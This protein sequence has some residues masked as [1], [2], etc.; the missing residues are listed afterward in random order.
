[1]LGQTITVRAGQAIHT[2]ASDADFPGNR[3]SRVRLRATKPSAEEPRAL[4]LPM[5]PE[6]IG[7]LMVNVSGRSLVRCRRRDFIGTDG[8]DGSKSPSTCERRWSSGTRRSGNQIE[9]HDRQAETRRVGRSRFASRTSQGA[10]HGLTRHP[11]TS[12]DAMT[13]WTRHA[14]GASMRTSLKVRPAFPSRALTHRSAC[15]R[16]DRPDSAMRTGRRSSNTPAR[17]VQFR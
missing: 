2:R 3:A 9:A 15:P 5:L 11:V 1:M 4:G 8:S 14:T 16:L 7:R 17:L 10:R 6:Q 13:D 12:Q